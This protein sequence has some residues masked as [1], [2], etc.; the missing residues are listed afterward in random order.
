MADDE[1]DP[2]LEA[3]L[4]AARRGDRAEFDRLFVRCQRI[5]LRS[6]ERQM[7]RRLR[8]RESPEDVAQE[9]QI[10]AFPKLAEADF[11]NLAAFHAWIDMLVFH[12][13]VDDDRREF[14]P[15]RGISPR[16]LE[17]TT[18]GKDGDDV[19]L[20]DEVEA[21][22]LTPSKDAARREEIGGLERLLERIPPEH[23]EILRM[24]HFEWL[25]VEEISARTGRSEEAVKK[26]IARGYEA[27]RKV[28]GLGRGGSGGASE[29]NGRGA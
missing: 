22:Q 29:G 9:V 20:R 1:R 15:T 8:K 4:D 3:L 11:P 6:V 23:R 17:D 28:L 10:A 16:S 13:L 26:A 12:T 25:E 24:A 7:G 21:D 14:G 27:C 18:P 2:W 5:I 19:W